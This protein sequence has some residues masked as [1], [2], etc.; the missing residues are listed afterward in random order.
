MCVIKEKKTTQMHSFKNFN[1]SNICCSAC[2]T[3]MLQADDEDDV[4]EEQ[5]KSPFGSS[6]RT[7]DATDYKPI[8][9]LD[10]CLL[11][12][13]LFSLSSFDSLSVSFSS[14]LLACCV[15]C[16]SLEFLD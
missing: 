6:F 10:F 12:T 7:F 16:L 1:M 3:A 15:C 14:S 4:M 2:Y 13:H 5:I 8:G 9:R 11:L